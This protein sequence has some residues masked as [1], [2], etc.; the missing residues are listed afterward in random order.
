MRVL[1]KS[2]MMFILAF[3]RSL[4]A[5]CT[6]SWSV[7]A[8]SGTVAVSA[9]FWSMAAADFFVPAFFFF[10]LLFGSAF[11]SRGFDLALAASSSNCDVRERGISYCVT[12]AL[13]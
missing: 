11:S 10:F 5:L 4:M 3:C 7:I 12:R 13:F 9:A 2:Q 6:A 1:L 8:L